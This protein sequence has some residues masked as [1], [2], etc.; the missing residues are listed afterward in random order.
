MIQIPVGK[1]LRINV[2]TSP[3]TDQKMIIEEDIAFSLSST[4]N[5]L[6]SGGNTKLVDLVGGLSKEL[7]GKGFSGQ[8][9]QM[10]IQVWEGTA[11]LSL[12]ITV[13]FYLDKENPDGKTQV[14]EPAIALAKLPL[15]EE[16][17]NGNLIPPGPTLLSSITGSQKG[18]GAKIISVEVGKILYL[19][20][21]IVKAAEPIFSNETDTNDYPIWSK[22]SL[23]I[24][25]TMTATSTILD[26]RSSN[27][28][29]SGTRRGGGTI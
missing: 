1:E 21:A 5:P 20:S 14:Y 26:D 7:T 24:M 8:F 15:P 29:A 19:K 23:D 22:V 18:K 2:N 13:G 12:K 10:G 25:S 11:P 9:K 16:G 3:V 17:S 27:G 6:L 4:F 28:S